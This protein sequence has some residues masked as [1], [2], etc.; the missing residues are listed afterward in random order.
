MTSPEVRAVLVTIPELGAVTIKEGKVARGTKPLV[1][2][3]AHRWEPTLRTAEWMAARGN[4]ADGEYFVCLYDGWREYSIYV[5]PAR[6]RYVRWGEI[7]QESHR[8]FAGFGVAREPRFLH[9][10]NYP[11]VYPVLPRLVLAYARH[12][13]DPSVILLPDPE[14]FATRGYSGFLDQVRAAA[15]AL[16]PPSRRL[17]G[18]SLFWR[19][20][21][22]VGAMTY[23]P[24]R[25]GHRNWFVAASR[26][27]TER[28]LSFGSMAVLSARVVDAALVHWK[29]PKIPLAEQLAAS[30]LLL[31]LDGMV[32]AWSG[33][34]WKLA[35]E[36]TVP[37]R[38]HTPWE[39]WYEA[40]LIPWRHYVPIL[41][42]ADRKGPGEEAWKEV[43][44]FASEPQAKEAAS[45]PQAKAEGA[46]GGEG[47]GEAEA[48]PKEFAPK[49]QPEP[50]A[51]TWEAQKTFYKT[52]ELALPSWKAISA[53]HAWC[54]AHPAECDRIAAE[55]AALTREILRDHAGLFDA[56]LSS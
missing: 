33:R 53:A 45:E 25:A 6:R 48:I 56:A 52:Y 50:K 7:A 22:N 40:Q 8:G 54:L 51:A 46:G 37:V 24:T 14:F 16:G 2:V 18:A 47:G 43:V 10:P 38:P 34:F 31:D 27:E 29:G 44:V 5:P 19:S 17:R 11:E 41:E 32:G 42:E 21:A 3:V 20:G 55:G 30:P 35:S 4:L 28:R 23:G 15:P 12:R 13:G 1:N 36:A 49:G 26:G 9:N 39:Q